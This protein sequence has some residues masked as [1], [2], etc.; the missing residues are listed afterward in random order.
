MKV[1]IQR[2]K[3]K[4][5]KAFKIYCRIQTRANCIKITKVQVQRKKNPLKKRNQWNK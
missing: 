2:K 4:E 1:K 5:R 3:E